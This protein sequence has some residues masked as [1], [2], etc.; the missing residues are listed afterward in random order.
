MLLAVDVGNTHTRI[1][2]YRGDRLVESWRYATVRADTADQLAAR[3]SSLLA[4]RGMALGELTGS[5]VSSVVPALGLEYRRLSERYLGGSCVLVGP[6][7][8]VG[9]PV[10]VEN[11]DEL[12]PDRLVN[13]VAAHE[14]FKGACAVVD[15]GTAITVDAVS[16]QGEFLGGAIAPGIRLS[17]DAL[18][19]HAAARLPRVELTAP[20][21]AIGRSTRGALRAGA[22]LGFAGAT[23]A[24]V[25]RVREELGSGARSIAT[26]GMAAAIVP[27]CRSI[28]EI[29]ELLTLEGL[30]LIHDRNS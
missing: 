6:D 22:V 8:D 13:A 21:Q 26:G 2:A 30:R 11:P 17:M 1:G 25:A 9:M 3:I 14:R 12:G 27:H 19:E 24:I 18:S 10:Q 4:L 5:A 15:F 28:D 16:A 29:D 7:L 20:E 23:D